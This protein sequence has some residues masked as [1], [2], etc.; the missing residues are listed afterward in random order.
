MYKYLIEAIG[1]AV[2]VTAKLLT[3]ANP[4]VM[5][6]IYFATLWMTQGITTGFLTP[7][8]P[9]A[10]YSLGRMTAQDAIYN[11]IAQIAGALSAIVLFKPIKGF[12]E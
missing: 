8:G 2:I 5:G 1:V 12:L 9:I 3:E 6:L 11:L 7:F 4:I 10:Y